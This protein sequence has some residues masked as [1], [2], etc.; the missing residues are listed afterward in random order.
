MRFRTTL[1]IS[2]G[3]LVAAAFAYMIGA[4][5][6]GYGLTLLNVPLWLFWVRSKLRA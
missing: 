4:R 5:W 3:L 6:G 2:I 1:S